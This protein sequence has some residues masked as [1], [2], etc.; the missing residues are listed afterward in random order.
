MS[1]LLRFFEFLLSIFLRLDR[2]PDAVSP[3]E[4][5]TRYIFA[6]KH[7]DATLGTV[8]PAAFLPST[9][10]SNISVYRTSRCGEWRIWAIG[11]HFVT[12]RRPD[13]VTLRARGDVAAHIIRQQG[14][15]VAADPH[16]H[17]RHAVVANWPDDKPQRKIRA[18][19]LAER[20]ALCI[21][22]RA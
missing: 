15:S 7:F 14:L 18:M 19:A 4:R 13:K 11:D 20:A 16:P 12:R 6:E 3:D 22:P 1:Y 2:V 5:T 10:T 17:P 9:K 8:R 21:C